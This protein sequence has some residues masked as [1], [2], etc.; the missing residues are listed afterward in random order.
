MTTCRCGTCL[1]A[2]GMLLIA[3]AGASGDVGLTYLGAF[4]AFPGTPSVYDGGLTYYP[5]GNGGAG[6]LFISRSPVGSGKEVWEI[7]IPPLVITTDINA[8]NTAATLTSFDVNT[9]PNGLVW[10][11]ADDKLYYSAGVYGS[12]QMPIRSINR[13]GTGES[14]VQLGPAWNEGGAGLCILPEAWAAAN[15]AGKSMVTIG[16]NRGIVFSSCDPWN[17]P[18][19][20]TQLWKYGTNPQMTGYDYGDAY[21]GIVWVEVDTA[22]DLVVTG[23]NLPGPVATIWFMRASDFANRASVVPQPYQILSVQ[24][25][26]FTTAKALCGA[27]Y[28]SVNHILYAYEG[29]YGTAVVVHAWSAFDSTFINNPPSTITNLAASNPT[30]TSITLSWTA[31]SDD[32]D[33]GNRAAGYDVRYSTSAIANDADFAAATQVTG[34]PTPSSPGLP[35]QMV[36]TGLTRGTLYYFAVKSYDSQASY[37]A[38]SNV[39]SLTTADDTVAPGQVTDLAAVNVQSRQLLLRWT[40]VG[41]DGMSGLASSYDI[42]YSTGP[43]DDGNFSSATPVPQTPLP[44]TPKAAGQTETLLVTSLSPSTTYYFAMKVADDLPNWSVLSNVV[45]VT[46]NPPDVTPPAAVTDLAAASSDALSANLTWTATGDDG[47]IGTAAGYEIRYSTSTITEDNWASATLAPNIL[48]PQAAGQTEHHTVIGLQPSTTY[49]F[50]LKVKD[51]EANTSGISNVAS[52]TTPALTNLPLVTTVVIAEKAGATTSNYP[53]TLSMVFAKGDVA[54]NVTVRAGSLVL[55]TQTDVKV[56]WPDG[57]VRHALVSFV[58]PQLAASQ[59]LTVEILAGGP[60]YNTGWVTKDQLLA[61]DFEAQMSIVV[62]STTFSASARQMLQNLTGVEYWMQGGIATEFIIRDFAANA[63]NQLN[64]SYRVRVYPSAGCIRVSTVV[65]NTWI[66]ARGNITYDFNLSLGRSV[67]QSVFAKTGFTHYHDARWHKVFWQGTTPP[68][69]EIRYNLPYLI[70]TGAVPNYDTSAVVPTSTITSQYNSWNTSAHDI[71]EGAGLTKYFPTTGGRSEI[72]PYPLWASLYL[73]SMDYRLA[74]VT[75]NYGDLSGSIPMHFRESDQARSFYKHPI[76]VDD[77]PTI[78]TSQVDVG[79]IQQYIDPADRFPPAVGDLNTPWDVDLAHQ[80]SLAYIPYLVTGD[81]YYLEE[82][83]FW[84]C[85]DLGAS[86]AG[87]RCGTQCWL[88]DQIRGN[89]WAFR[90]II[91]AASMTPDS[92]PEKAY[93]NAKIAN[94]I[95]RWKG[96]YI[97]SN[98][99]TIRTYGAG[100]Y[101]GDPSIDPNTCS[102]A[103]GVWQDDYLTWSFI[104]AWQMG[105]PTL[106]MVRWGGKGV[107]DRF[108]DWPGWNRFRAAPYAMPVMGKDAGGNPVHYQTWAEV[109]NGFTDKVGPSSFGSAV[110]NPN[111]YEYAARGVLALVSSLD[112]GQAQF[113]WTASQLPASTYTSDMRWGFVPIPYTPGDVNFDVH[114]DVSDLLMLARSWGLSYGTVGFDTA[115]DFNADFAVDVADLLILAGNFGQ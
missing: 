4:R 85:F 61:S 60:N 19:S 98:G 113:T 65:D 67:P 9:N 53:I 105:Y 74:Q 101:T 8:L 24:D 87:Y 78:W 25:K 106:E 35:E 115:S 68:Q 43:I 46:M 17:T 29:A 2:V 104:H 109:N 55:P 88:I 26:M 66:N 15:A 21:K 34:E 84:A 33:P 31:P 63:F 7:T 97:G 107:V 70:A 11:S 62:G 50:A 36:V 20:F 13:D 10:R 89:A 48:A 23:S 18:M 92:M 83:H 94:N 77:R 72:G 108:T 56:R 81:L 93:L 69:I 45:Q 110:G 54:D 52:C 114:V 47:G 71:M 28:D 99:P 30:F 12:G 103:A 91:D 76:S 51:E 102:Y 79:Y 100:T 75:I 32:H 1:L 86:N 59:S 6:S 90:N 96:M 5:A 27:A 58:I 82:M 49:Y 64:V 57:S 37:S 80:P 111:S 3:G 41:D 73:A 14:A 40:A 39:V 112:N 38:L 16:T 22:Q 95:T 42:R 44:L